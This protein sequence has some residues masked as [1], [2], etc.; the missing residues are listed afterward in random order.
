VKGATADS[1]WRLGP[2]L[3]RLVQFKRSVPANGAARL[4]NPVFLRS[5][6]ERLAPPLFVL[7]ARPWPALLQISRNLRNLGRNRIHERC[8]DAAGQQDAAQIVEDDLPFVGIE[9]SAI[10]QHAQV[11]RHLS[12]LLRS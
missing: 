8:I 2:P 4:F 1:L 6:G 10:H 5:S 11:H 3:R 9:L 12:A 7:R